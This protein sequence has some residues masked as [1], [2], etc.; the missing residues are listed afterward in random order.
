MEAV[1]ITLLGGV[2][3]VILGM[4]LGFGLA[5]YFKSTFVIPFQ[6]M[7]L[8]FIVCVVTG[9]VSGLYPAVKAA[10]LDPIESLRYE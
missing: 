2:V 3:G 4:G 7:L 5:L 9:V 10:R 8:A 6:W 1:V